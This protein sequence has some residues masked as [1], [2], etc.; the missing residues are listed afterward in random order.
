ML[1]PHGMDSAVECLWCEDKWSRP[2]DWELLESASL[3]TSRPD[4][5]SRWHARVDGKWLIYIILVRLLLAQSV[6]VITC[7]GRFINPRERERHTHT[8]WQWGKKDRLTSHTSGW[9]CWSR[10]PANNLGHVLLLL[11]LKASSGMTIQRF[12]LTWLWLQRQCGQS[13]RTRR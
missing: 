1:R 5:D 9:W 8:T 10:S 2:K 7:D 11:W 13:F 3:W 6:P 4:W 12:C